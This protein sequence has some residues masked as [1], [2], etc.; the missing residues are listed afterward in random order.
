MPQNALHALEVEWQFG[1]LE[2][3]NFKVPFLQC[4]K[5]VVVDSHNSFALPPVKWQCLNIPLVIRL[6]GDL[7]DQ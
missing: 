6:P 7:F 3:S 5:T 2:Q 4:L 1:P